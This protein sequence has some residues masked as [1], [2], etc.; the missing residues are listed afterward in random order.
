MPNGRRKWIGKVKPYVFGNQWGMLGERLVQ[1]SRLEGKT[2]GDGGAYMSRCETDVGT[3]RARFLASLKKWRLC[4]FLPAA[5][6]LVLL[7]RQSPELTEAIYSE[8]IYPVLAFILGGITSLL[9]FSLMELLICLI[10]VGILALIGVMI[11]HTIRTRN[12]KAGGETVQE[13]TGGRR[14]IDLIRRLCILVSIVIFIFV[15]FCGLNYY[16]LEFTAFSGLTVRDSTVAELEALCTELAENANR[17]REQVTPDQDAVTVLPDG[18]LETAKKARE[19]FGKLSEKF[20][21]L[22]DLPITPKPVVNSWWMSMM[23]ITGVFTPFTFEANVNIAAPDYGI[24]ATMCHELAHTRGFM[25]EDEANF[26]SYLACRDSDYVQFQYSG[27]MLGLVHS[28]NRLYSADQEAFM[29][30]NQMLSQ[31]VRLD[32][33]YNDAYWQNYEGPVAEVSNT[34]NH[35]YLKANNQTDGVRSYGRMVD[36]LLA[37]YRSRHGIA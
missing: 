2:A 29:R 35:I 3:E 20:E 23:Q 30:V 34:V 33:A 17:L 37:D 22:P 1:G 14:G 10:L 25:R 19:T 6:L 16:R 18:A 31:G 36:L 5:G 15:V 24:P 7:A 4:L 32:F 26:I 9:P 12:T 11:V 13:D 8:R 27:A 28:L 21:V